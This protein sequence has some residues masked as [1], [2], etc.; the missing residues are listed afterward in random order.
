MCKPGILRKIGMV[1]LVTAY[2]AAVCADIVII[3][4]KSMPDNVIDAKTA[5]KLWLGKTKKVGD[6]GKVVIL[7]QAKGS[8]IKDAFYKSVTNKSSAQA[9]AYWAK[10]VFTGK[11]LPPKALSNDQEVIELV[12]SSSNVIGYVDSSSVDDSV[13]VLYKVK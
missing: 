4:N 10:I 5:K 2:S 7:D 13:K 8:P 3:G 11:A 12:R 6:V 9:K 1:L